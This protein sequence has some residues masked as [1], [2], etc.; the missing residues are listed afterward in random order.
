[1]HQKSLQSFLKTAE[2]L[3]VSGLTQQQAEDTHSVSIGHGPAVAAVRAPLYCQLPLRPQHLAQIQNLANSGGRTPLNTH[4]QSLPH[5]HHGS[6]HDDGG[7]STLFSRQGAGS[8]PPTAVPSLPSH[9]N[10]QLLKRM[11]MM[12]RSSAAAAAEETSHAFKRLRGSDNSLPLSGAVGSGS[13]NNSPD[14]PPLHARSAS[15]QQ[16]PAD[17]ST[18]KHHNNNNT[19]PLKEEKRECPSGNWVSDWHW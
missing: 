17:F 8:P 16:T 12:H 18:I 4:T 1:M 7:S 5:P 13:N 2:V 11:A 10:N 14:L 19:P 3:R 6:L 9:I 15:P